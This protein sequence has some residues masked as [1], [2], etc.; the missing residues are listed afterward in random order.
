M[1]Q[2]ATALHEIAVELENEQAFYD[3]YRRN[4]NGSYARART[5]IRD[6]CRGRNHSSVISLTSNR[7][8]LRRYFD[9]NYGI[10]GRPGSTTDCD[11]VSLLEF[12]KDTVREGRPIAKASDPKPLFRVGDLWD[13]TFIRSGTER[14]ANHGKPWTREQLNQLE[15]LFLSGRGMQEICHAMQ[16]PGN[17]ILTRLVEFRFLRRVDQGDYTYVFRVTNWAVGLLP[18]LLSPDPLADD[19]LIDDAA[20]S[21]LYLP[22][23]V[24]ASIDDIAEALSPTPE[25]NIMSKDTIEISTK[26]LIN[27][28][29]INDFK[30]AQIYDLIAAQEA[31]IDRLSAIKTKPK[32]L[33]AEIEERQA[34]IA[35]LVAHL[36]SK[37]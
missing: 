14:R 8:H 9:D 3:E 23:S 26:T 6:Y 5:V 35:A 33:M 28:Q 10:M 17:G 12:W 29:D 4:A 16:R 30:D 19:H 13:T 31:E 7:E 36:D 11:H 24:V 27:G 21:S 1:N 25:E 18:R 15:Q 20:E 22:P 32:K 37:D 2:L 34:G